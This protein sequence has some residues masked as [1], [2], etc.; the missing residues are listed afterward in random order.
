MIAL[1]LLATAPALTFFSGNDLYSQCEMET[2]MVCV[3]YILGVSDAVSDA[4]T[5]GSLPRLVCVSRDST[6]EQL[7]DIVVKYLRDNP[8][9]RDKSAASLTVAALRHA[10]P[11]T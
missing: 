5:A 9:T 8:D 7:K 4:E 3:G 1:A 2:P 6:P 10:A 11:C